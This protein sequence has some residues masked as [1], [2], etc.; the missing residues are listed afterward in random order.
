MLAAWIWLGIGSRAEAGC[1]GYVTYRGA[2][3]HVPHRSAGD[4][5]DN[6]LTHEGGVTR[7][8]F[9]DS[10]APMQ[11]PCNGPQC[12]KGPDQPAS[13]TTA[14]VIERTHEL[15]IFEPASSAAGRRDECWSV[16]S[17][18]LLSDLGVIR[19]IDHPPQLH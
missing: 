14:I 2:D 8:A 11:R 3:G 9:N 13:T 4:D 6:H 19:E 1:G 16:H 5:G 7:R 12:G 15:P 10:H 17:R 18:H